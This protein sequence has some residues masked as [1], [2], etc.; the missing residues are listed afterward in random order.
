MRVSIQPQA[1][2]RRLIEKGKVDGNIASRSG[3]FFRSRPTEIQP[4]HSLRVQALIA[5]GVH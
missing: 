3:I 1:D 2:R 5:M 4:A